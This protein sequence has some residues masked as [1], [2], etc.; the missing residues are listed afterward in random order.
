MIEMTRTEL[1]EAE[2]GSHSLDL[3]WCLAENDAIIIIVVSLM[4]DYCQN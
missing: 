3:A 1:T 2:I 4:Y